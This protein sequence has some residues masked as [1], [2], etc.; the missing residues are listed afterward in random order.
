MKKI[1]LKNFIVFTLALCTGVMQAAPPPPVPPP[2]PGLPIDA[3][4]IILFSVCLIYGF[5]KFNIQN[6]KKA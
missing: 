1:T 6:T 2:P 5:Y 4:I 3:N